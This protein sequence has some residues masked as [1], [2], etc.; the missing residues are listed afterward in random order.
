MSFPRDPGNHLAVVATIAGLEDAAENALL[1]PDLAWLQLPLL[2]ETGHLGTRARAARRAV[3]RSAG[4]KDEV[5][6]VI[7]RVAGR[8]EEFHMVDLGAAGARDP[9]PPQR[10]ANPQRH[11]R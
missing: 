8:A 3:V 5:S 10:V 1:P 2:G 9:V 7:V 4:A 11:V 6:T